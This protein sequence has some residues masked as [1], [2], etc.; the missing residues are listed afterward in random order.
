MRD[1]LYR[2]GI[3]QSVDLTYALTERQTIWEYAP[4]SRAA[5]DYAAFVRF[6]AGESGSGSRD[7]R[8]PEKSGSGADD[9]A[10]AEKAQT[11]V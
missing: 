2:P 7:A 4:R 9:E 6:I 8:G 3:R 5:K 10:A 11:V 1:R